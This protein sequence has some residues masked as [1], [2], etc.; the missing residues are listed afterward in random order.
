MINVYWWSR[1]RD[2]NE[3][4]E[5]FGDILVPYLLDKTT[6]EKYRWMIPNNNRYLRIFNKKHHYLIIGSILRK[7]TNHSIIWGAGIMFK[8][9][10]V[11]KAKFLL[12][13][14]PR[15]RKRLMELGYNVPLRYGDPALLISLF[16]KPLK[17]KRYQLG[18]IPHYLDHQEV[19]HM[20]GDNKSIKIIDLLTNDPQKVIDEMNNCEKILSSSL[21]GIICG[22]ALGIPSLWMKISDKLL[23]DI[24]F[25]DYYES[26]DINYALNISFKKS[27]LEELIQIFV[28]NEKKSLP[29][30]R[31]INERLSDIVDTFPFKKSKSFKNA[32]SMHFNRN[33]HY[34]D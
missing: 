12:V 8:D 15:T 1:A 27:S 26:M 33:D 24:K 2:L 20:Y 28:D 30:K 3:T 4:L 25:Y 31:K 11:A 19:Q 16:N 29:T 13:R 23:D 17:E 9:S 34:L 10:K 7:A 21:H 5:N 14:G 22:H 18:I 6:S 32:L